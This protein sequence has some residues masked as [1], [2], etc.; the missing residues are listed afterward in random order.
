MF[1]LSVTVCA[2]RES[3][4]REKREERTGEE[5]SLMLNKSEKQ[6]AAGEEERA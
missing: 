1:C 2:S 3:P 6:V 5:S 4:A